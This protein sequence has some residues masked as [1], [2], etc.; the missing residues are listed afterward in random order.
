MEGM[1]L[2]QCIYLY[3]IVKRSS[4]DGLGWKQAINFG[5]RE[6]AKIFAHYGEESCNINL[7]F[8]FRMLISEQRNEKK[9]VLWEP[10]QK[11]VVGNE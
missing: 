3:K 10:S 7:Q 4:Y 6:G 8:D 1:I 2:G 9:N 11:S 5:I